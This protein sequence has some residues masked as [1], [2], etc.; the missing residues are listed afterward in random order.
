MKRGLTI[1]CCF[2]LVWSLAGCG[3]EDPY[4]VDTVVRIPVDPTDV[5]AARTEDTT[6]L[7][8]ETAEPTEEMTEV[9]TEEA[10]EETKSSGSSGGRKPSSGGNK[11]PSGEKETEPTQTEPPATEPVT[12][13]PEETEPAVTEPAATEPTE[14]ETQPET[15]APE[16][17]EGV[18]DP[19]GY[20]L[21]SLEYAILA[22]INAY[23]VEAGLQELTLSTRLSGIAAIRAEEV[24]RVWSHTRPDGRYYTSVMTDYGYGFSLSAENLIYTSGAGDAAVMVAKWM[25]ADNQ[26][27]LLNPD[28]T[29][30]GIGIYRVDGVTYVSNILI[31]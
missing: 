19:S 20:V 3:R 15:T 17:T 24:S 4:R 5:P 23:R 21:G 25:S 18:Y 28:F 6:E 13:K 12:T 1:L 26:D 11:K 8:T 14:Q 22:E 31:G 30:A 29:T 9:T 10:T 16:E 2:L 7:P 27:N